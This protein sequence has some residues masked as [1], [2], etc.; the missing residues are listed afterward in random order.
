MGC[1]CV[2]E[3]DELLLLRVDVL[4]LPSLALGRSDRWVHC[5]HQAEGLADLVEGLQGLGHLLERH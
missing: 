2:L 4:V 1:D 5:H 3:I